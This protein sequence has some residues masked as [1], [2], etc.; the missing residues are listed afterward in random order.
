M[1]RAA[2]AAVD[3]GR[4][5]FDALVV[6][7]APSRAAALAYYTFF[8]I[9]PVVII[10]IAVAGIVFGHDEAWGAIRRQLHGLI[11][12][13]A[14]QAVQD[15]VTGANGPRSGVIA[16]LLGSLALLFGAT[17]VFAE[18]QDALNVIWN[19]PPLKIHGVLGFFRTRFL[20]FVMV[21][22]VGFLLLVS[23]LVNV[24]L[25]TFC[26]WVG[27]CTRSIGHSL[28]SG[29]SFL[30]ITVMFALIFKL[31][32]DLKV[33]WRN[34]WLGAALT[35]ALFTLGKYV[36]GL[37]LGRTAILS[38]YG[39]AASLA[40]FLLWVHY[41]SMILLV[42]AELSHAIAARDQGS[43]KVDAR[44]PQRHQLRDSHA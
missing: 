19:A 14:T 16:T 41:S 6:H 15:L 44:T 22:G 12:A 8:S 36:L 34:V 23:L 25:S 29:V 31:L 38:T 2:R 1:R 10:A 3:L 39:A 28:N 11:G 32:P 33:A 13:T 7:R 43:A 26:H 4:A 37:V 17:G 18:L 5:T 35:A 40:A 24:A 9:A 42:G 27:E 20:S 21:L 30:V